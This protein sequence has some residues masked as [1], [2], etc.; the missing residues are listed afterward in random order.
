[1][2]EIAA[3]IL[4][5]RQ[6]LVAELLG[7]VGDPNDQRVPGVTRIRH[8]AQ[9]RA[10]RFAGRYGNGWE[11][12]MANPPGKLLKS[13]DCGSPVGTATHDQHDLHIFLFR[14]FD[15]HRCSA[16]IEQRVFDLIVRLKLAR[17]NRLSIAEG[18]R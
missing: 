8:C 12:S 1:M 3:R 13:K 18:P 4:R 6:E 14:R 5:L 15:A 17:H 16:C 2:T 10:W 7:V 9:H 11:T